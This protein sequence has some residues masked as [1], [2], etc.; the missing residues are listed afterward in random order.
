MQ[1]FIINYFAFYNKLY[2]RLCINSIPFVKAQ[3]E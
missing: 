3:K 1:Q 2:H